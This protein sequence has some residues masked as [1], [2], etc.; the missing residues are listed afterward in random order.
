MFFPAR[1]AAAGAWVGQGGD[2]PQDA[3]RPDQGDA[4]LH[5]WCWEAGRGCLWAAQDAGAF[6]DAMQALRHAM[7]QLTKVKMKRQGALLAAE[8][9]SPMARAR[10]TAEQPGLLIGRLAVAGEVVLLAARTDEVGHQV[11]AQPV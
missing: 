10:L 9:A 5:V 7:S 2:L 11:A 3:G 4:K 6:Q 8:D 1:A